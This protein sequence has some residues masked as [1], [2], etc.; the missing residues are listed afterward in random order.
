M[1]ENKIMFE[2]QTKKYK[3][4]RLRGTCPCFF[5]LTS[6]LAARS[7]GL[8]LIKTIYTALWIRRQPQRQYL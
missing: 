6:A 3:S 5:A 7:Y 4:V 2:I 8:G 1:Q